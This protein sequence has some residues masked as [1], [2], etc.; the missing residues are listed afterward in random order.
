MDLPLGA[1]SFKSK[2]F[3]FKTFVDKNAVKMILGDFLKTLFE[4]YQQKRM[5]EILKRHFY[6][7]ESLESQKIKLNI[8]VKL[9]NTEL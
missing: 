7:K 2:G 9:K 6:P 4:L 8:A 5:C 1:F 3:F